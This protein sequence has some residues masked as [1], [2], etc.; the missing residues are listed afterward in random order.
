VHREVHP[1]G[2]QRLLDLLGEERLAG[3]LRERH[4]GDPVPSVRIVTSSTGGAPGQRGEQRRDVARLP[5]RERRA[6][7]AEPEGAARSRSAPPPRE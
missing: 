3:D 5:E 6:A 1:P 7:G 4:V 2:E